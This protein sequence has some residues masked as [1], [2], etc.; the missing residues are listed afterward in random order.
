MY[1]RVGEA[2]PP[3][4]QATAIQSGELTETLQQEIITLNTQLLPACCD[5]ILIE[6]IFK[7]IMTNRVYLLL[8]AHTSTVLDQTSFRIHSLMITPFYITVSSYG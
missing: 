2:G 5:T 8:V 1:Y 6:F 4:N 3:S 7:K